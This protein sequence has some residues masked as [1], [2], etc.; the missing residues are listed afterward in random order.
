MTS[1]SLRKL[2]DAQVRN[3]AAGGDFLGCII[4]WQ[5]STDIRITHTDLKTTAINCQIPEKFIPA[6]VKPTKAFKKA[7]K[8]L[9]ASAKEQELLLRYIGKKCLD[10]DKE[11]TV[12]VVEETAD[13]SQ[14]T[15]N[16]NQLGIIKYSGG[17]IEAVIPK[18]QNLIDELE[19]LFDFYQ[20]HTSDDI[21]KMLLIFTLECATRLTPGGGSYF[22]PS[23]YTTL[24]NSLRNFITQ[25][26]QKSPNFASKIFILE[27]YDSPQNQTDLAEIAT[28]NLE[29]EILEL[30]TDLDNFL[31][32][33]KTTGSKFKNGLTLRMT[34][35]QELRSRV[36]AF[37]N[38]LNFQSTL[39]ENRL[40]EV[41]DAIVDRINHRP[42]TDQ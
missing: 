25:I 14:S 22:V 36:Q 19:K 6:A 5:I 12:G 41:E 7:I 2:A 34:Q 42:Q 30:A 26:A 8:K 21:R 18:H 1:T 39:L 3:K 27:T 33:A 4:G 35:A 29:S 17:I 10:D 38:V 28:S 24:L 9:Q 16:Y 40:A 20:E 31:A 23:M 32:E 11:I 15:L 37:A 13:I